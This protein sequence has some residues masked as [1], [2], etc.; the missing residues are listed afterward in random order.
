MWVFETRNTR[1]RAQKVFKSV[2]EVRD[3]SLR[4]VRDG[5]LREVRESRSGME[6][7]VRCAMAGGAMEA[8][9]AW[10]KCVME[11]CARRVMEVCGMEPAVGRGGLSSPVSGAQAKAA[12]GK[13]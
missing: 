1:I 11:V 5:S 2:T 4:E 9:R 6:A 10:R 3:G 7:C 8:R 12:G 13:P